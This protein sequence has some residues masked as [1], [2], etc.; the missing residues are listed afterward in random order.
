M[1]SV[2]SQKGSNKLKSVE[3]PDIDLNEENIQ[4][5]RALI[6]LQRKLDGYVGDERL[7]VRGQVSKLINDA[8][9]KEN[10]CQIFVGWRPWL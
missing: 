9:N 5:Q 8:T 10:L 3:I 1:S 6:S 4:A 7:S 2:K